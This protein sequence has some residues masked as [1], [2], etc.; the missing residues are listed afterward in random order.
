MIGN[1]NAKRKAGKQAKQLS[2]DLH[3]CIEC[4]QCQTSEVGG[5]CS[6]CAARGAPADTKCASNARAQHGYKADDEQGSYYDLRSAK[7]QKRNVSSSDSSID[8]SDEDKEE[9]QMLEPAK[10]S[11]SI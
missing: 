5:I 2:S 4:H 3:Q 8:S 1:W 7:R 6:I 11:S 9:M 10:E